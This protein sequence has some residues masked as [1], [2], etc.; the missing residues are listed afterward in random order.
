MRCDAIQ[1]GKGGGHWPLKRRNS[2]WQKLGYISS[3]AT[4]QLC[5]K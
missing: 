2:S 5:K 3:I 1:T 4:S